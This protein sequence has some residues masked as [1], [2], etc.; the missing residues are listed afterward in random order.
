MMKV[1]AFIIGNVCRLFNPMTT[2]TVLNF[3]SESLYIARFCSVM[4]HNLIGME[5]TVYEIPTC[6]PTAVHTGSLK[7][8]SNIECQ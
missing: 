8:A 2:I 4:K 6:S 7:A 5:L 3:A 1:C